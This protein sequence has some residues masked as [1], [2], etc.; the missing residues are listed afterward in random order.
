MLTFKMADFFKPEGIKVNSIQINGATMSEESLQK[1]KPGWRIIARFQNLFFRPPE[2]TADL[3]YRLCTSIEYRN[4]TGIQ[5]NHRAELMRPA[6]TEG[7]LLTDIKQALGSDVYPSYADRK[8]I[9]EIV[10]NRCREMTREY[11]T[12]DS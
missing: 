7:G 8:D 2:Y 10:W 3:Y 6:V 1:I 11:I 5:F 4:H 9:T 12:L